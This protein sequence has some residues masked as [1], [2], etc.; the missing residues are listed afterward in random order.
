MSPSVSLSLSLSLS[1]F[2]IF[3]FFVFVLAL[4]FVFILLQRLLDIRSKLREPLVERVGSRLIDIAVDNEAEAFGQLLLP[5][6]H[7]MRGPFAVAARLELGHEPEFEQSA[8]LGR[9]AGLIADQKQQ[10]CVKVDD[11][12]APGFE[13]NRLNWISRDAL[14]RTSREIAQEVRI[15]RKYNLCKSSSQGDRTQQFVAIVE[16]EAD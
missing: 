6:R 14:T 5:E 1:F 16:S 7:Q 3:Y 12:S 9:D 8:V 11:R 2:F 10:A 13:M 15:P 4:L